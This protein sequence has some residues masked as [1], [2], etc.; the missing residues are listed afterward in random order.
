MNITC[1]ITWGNSSWKIQLN[2]IILW[3]ISYREHSNYTKFSLYSRVACYH[4]YFA[5]FFFS[6]LS[7]QITTSYL[8]WC[9]VFLATPASTDACYCGGHL[10][11][12]ALIM[13]LL[14]M[15]ICVDCIWSSVL[16]DFIQNRCSLGG[17]CV[18]SQ[19]NRGQENKRFEHRVFR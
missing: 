17:R 4:W 15:R 19:Q 14:L 18:H 1:N 7:M 16:F 6:F 3:N 13:Q 5:L 12:N 10:S 9:F 11:D 8:L 2:M